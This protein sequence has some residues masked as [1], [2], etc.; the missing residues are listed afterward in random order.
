MIT[1]SIRR[2]AER[3]AIKEGKT[4]RSEC[5]SCANRIEVNEA[6]QSSFFRGVYPKPEKFTLLPPFDRG[7]LIWHY[8]TMTGYL[9]WEIVN[10]E[11]YVTMD[12]LTGTDR[13]GVMTYDHAV[14]VSL[15]LVI[16]GYEHDYKI[17]KIVTPLIEAMVKAKQPGKE[18]A[19]AADDSIERAAA[20]LSLFFRTVAWFNFLLANPD[21]K[22]AKKKS[23]TEA[24]INGLSVTA[25]P[26]K[27]KKISSKQ[28][29]RICSLW[30][31]S[32]HFRHYKNG[33]IV[34]IK[35]YLKG[36][37]REIGEK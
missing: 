5:L 4:L 23:S 35:P 26:A 25:D 9:E 29:Q 34:Y 11:E 19:A 16:D 20:I 12:V 3:I 24:D 2:S 8:P 30:S 36:K 31:V 33:K 28:R 18:I 21:Y 6:E 15:P 13:E 37:N 14:R 10:V 22:A 7:A 17:S 1:R 32:G 27:I